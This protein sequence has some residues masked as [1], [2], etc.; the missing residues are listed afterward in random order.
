MKETPYYKIYHAGFLPAGIKHESLRR[1]WGCY[2]HNEATAPNYKE[3]APDLFLSD[4]P[5]E[6]VNDG[7]FIDCLLHFNSII[8]ECFAFIWS[9]GGIVEWKNKQNICNFSM[10]R[11]HGL[12]VKISDEEAIAYASKC[13]E[14]KKSIL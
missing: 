11:R 13:F 6:Q 2:L 7:H 5:F 12:I 3:D 10:V 8:H 4:T 9:S 14:Q 1:W